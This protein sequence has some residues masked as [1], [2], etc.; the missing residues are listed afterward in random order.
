MDTGRLYKAI[1]HDTD[2]LTKTAHAGTALG[3]RYWLLEVNTDRV[4]THALT[5]LIAFSERSPPNT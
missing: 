1:Q 2:S 4:H 3:G 5:Q